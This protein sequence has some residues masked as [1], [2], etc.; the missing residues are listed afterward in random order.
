MSPSLYRLSYI[1]L[2]TGEI[3]MITARMSRINRRGSG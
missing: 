3:L 2:S 1:T